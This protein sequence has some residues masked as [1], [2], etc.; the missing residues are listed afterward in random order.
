LVYLVTCL[1][2]SRIARRR[3]GPDQTQQ[4]A[5]LLAAVAEVARGLVEG[6]RHLRQRQP[7][8][9]AL[10]TIAVQRFLTGVMFVGT[11][12]LYT[13]HGYLHRGFAGLGQVLTATVVGGVV[14]AV[15][16]PRVTRVIGTQRWITVVLL[17][18]AVVS[19]ALGTA[20]RHGALLVAG[21]LLGTCSQAAKICVDTLLQETV[22]DAFRGRVFSVYDTLVNVSFAAAAG[23]AAVVVP[24][25]GR[26]VPVLLVLAVGYAVTGAVYGWVVRRRMP[27]EPPEPVVT[28]R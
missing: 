2:A 19:A 9:R 15:I 28:S 8:A 18:S 25:N 26:S 6:V 3:L 10:I 17:V 5:P 7:A 11:L 24:D 4:P 20:Y 22:E 16:T 21:L 12:L 27:Y 14:A 13:E 1:L 23:V